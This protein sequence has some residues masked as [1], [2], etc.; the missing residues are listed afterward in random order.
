MNIEEIRGLGAEFYLNGSY[1]RKYNGRTYILKNL[2]WVEY[3]FI[4]THKELIECQY[5]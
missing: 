2:Q 3:C 4:F 5:L 1:F